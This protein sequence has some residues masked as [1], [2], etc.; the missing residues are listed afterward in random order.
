MT[1]V[2]FIYMWMLYRWGLE[3]VR[4][5]TMHDYVCLRYMKC[6]G[7]EDADV[8]T[9]YTMHD[10]VCF[11]YM[12]CVG[13]EDTD[14]TTVY[15]MHDYVCFRYMKCVGCEDTDVTTVYTMHDY[16]CFRYMKCVGCEDTDV[17][18]GNML[19]MCTDYSA[20][21]NWSSGIGNHTYNFPTAGKFNIK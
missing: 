20:L 6:V 11:R 4:L 14:V 2:E 17:T 9:V 13:C 1:N 12:K 19:A 15:T 3:Q 8:T 21:E 10:Y 16:V 7:C 5:Y 18:I